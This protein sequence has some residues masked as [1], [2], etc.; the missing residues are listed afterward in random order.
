MVSDEAL[1]QIVTIVVSAIT[2]ILG[3]C[4]VH[5]HR[6][7]QKAKSIENDRPPT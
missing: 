3:G 5:V 1:V 4:A 2:A 6:K 7:K